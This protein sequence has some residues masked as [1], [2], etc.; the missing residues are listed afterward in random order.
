MIIINDQSWSKILK[1]L[2]IIWTLST[3]R[4]IFVH[5]RRDG[6]GV[7][8]PATYSNGP[9]TDYIDW[10]HSCCSSLY[11]GIWRN[12]EVKLNWATTASF[13]L[14]SNWSHTNHPIIHSVQLKT[15]LNKPYININKNIWY[16][17]CFRSLLYFHLLV[18]DCQQRDKFILNL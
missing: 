8:T 4:D 15:F 7:C 17:W 1:C 5:M 10:G 3:V 13:H 2:K 18:I 14:L 12:R 16:T 6:Q 11:Q 9:N